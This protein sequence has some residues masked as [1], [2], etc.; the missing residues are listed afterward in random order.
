MNLEKNSPNLNRLTSCFSQDNDVEGDSKRVVQTC[1]I[2]I[3]N[4]FADKESQGNS[5]CIQQWF[6]VNKF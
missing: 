1:K 4:L 5:N 6:D 3:V 2:S